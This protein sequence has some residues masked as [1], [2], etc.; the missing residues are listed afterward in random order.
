MKNATVARGSH[1]TRLA[2]ERNTEFVATP[3]RKLPVSN[4]R[5]LRFREGTDMAR[6][7]PA[8]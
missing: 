3:R 1:F 8:K 2:E 7:E 6:T 4:H 5:F